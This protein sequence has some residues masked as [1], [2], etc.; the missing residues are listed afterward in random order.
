MAHTLTFYEAYGSQEAAISEHEEKATVWNVAY[1][2]NI[3]IV[4]ESASTVGQYTRRVYAVRE[5]TGK[6]QC[7]ATRME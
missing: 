6:N 1:K 7:R 3:T 5:W 4:V 2:D